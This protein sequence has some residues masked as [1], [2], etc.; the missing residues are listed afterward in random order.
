MIFALHNAAHIRQQN[1]QLILRQVGQPY[2]RPGQIHQS[3]AGESVFG[4]ARLQ[5][6]IAVKTSAGIQQKL[7]RPAHEES[8]ACGA[9][10]QDIIQNSKDLLVIGFASLGRP[11]LVDVHHFVQANQHALVS[12]FANKCRHEFQLIIDVGIIDDR[13]DPQGFARIR[14]CREF[15][16]QPTQRS[17]FQILIAGL[18]TFP[19]PAHDFREFEPSCQFFEVIQLF[20]DHFV[21]RQIPIFGFAMRRGCESL[22]HARQGSAVRPSPSGQV[23]RHF[24]VK[25]AS[26]PA[27]RMDA[28]IRRQVGEHH[29]Q[30]FLKSDQ[31]HQVHEKRFAGTVFA[32]D[33]SNC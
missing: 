9:S 30:A 8:K 19:I 23:S 24:G 26:L 14:A 5:G 10:L 16:P 29:D 1:E 2:H 33:E 17:R 12:G 15:S 3:T 7:R 22:N 28:T 31:P 20:P 6:F 11:K 21:G 13:T 27:C 32:N 18:V 25:S 4:Q